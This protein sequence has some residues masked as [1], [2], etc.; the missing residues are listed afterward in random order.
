[1]DEYTFN[2]SDEYT[3]DFSQVNMTVGLDHLKGNVLCNIN[4]T[5]M[6]ERMR[7]YHHKNWTTMGTYVYKKPSRFPKEQQDELFKLIVKDREMS[8]VSEEA[9]V[10]YIN[11][12]TEE[13]MEDPEVIKELKD[14]GIEVDT[15]EFYES[16]DGMIGDELSINPPQVL[17]NL[18]CVDLLEDYINL[19]K[20]D[21]VQEV[22]Q[23]IEEMVNKLG[24]VSDNYGI[25]ETIESEDP[26]LA[27]YLSFYEDTLSVRIVELEDYEEMTVEE[28]K[29]ML[30]EYLVGI[31][32]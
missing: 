24:L 22:E 11:T 5:D 4:L 30:C 14:E 32:N 15:E 2:F 8:L 29:K 31:K 26:I 20:D 19:I 7:E 21:H 25:Y 10:E 17:F 27:Y 23:Q 28:M 13:Y 12:I 6:V 9:T 16:V 3:F 18:M 1:M